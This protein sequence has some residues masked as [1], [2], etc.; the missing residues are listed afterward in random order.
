MRC[1]LPLL[2][3][4]CFTG[5]QP[6]P[7][8]QPAK[9]TPPAPPVV[10]DDGPPAWTWTQST[11]SCASLWPKSTRCAPATVVWRSCSTLRRPVDYVAGG[12]RY[13]VTEMCFDCTREPP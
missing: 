7:P 4:S 11:M 3:T 6:A 1:L 5:G 9:V 13:R 10:H 2:L 12:Q 8:S